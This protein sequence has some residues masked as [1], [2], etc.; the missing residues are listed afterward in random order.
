MKTVF[1]LV[2]MFLLWSENVLAQ[3]PGERWSETDKNEI[4]T[5]LEQSRQELLNTVKPLTE[6]QFFYRLDEKSWS[7]NDIVEHLGLIEEGYVREFWWALAQPTMPVSY[8]DSTAGADQRIRDYATSPNKSE[9]RGTNLPLQRYT[10]KE[11]CVRIFNTARD[12]SVEFFTKNA[13]VD[14]RS[15]YVFRKS[16]SGKREIRD[17]HQNALMMIAHT[18][19]HTNQLKQILTDPRF[20]KPDVIK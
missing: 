3:K 1:T 16:G 8:R 7:A 6:K 10:S 9:A 2:V 17:L 11:T 13:T 18:V 5:M 20:P 15:F 14:M 4:M 19:R 12:Q